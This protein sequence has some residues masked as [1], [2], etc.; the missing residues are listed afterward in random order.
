MTNSSFQRRH[1]FDLGVPRPTRSRLEHVTFETGL[2]C[3]AIGDVCGLDDA[4]L[5]TTG[6][7]ATENLFIHDGRSFFDAISISS[8]LSFAF[9]SFSS[10]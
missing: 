1:E 3:R 5:L 2:F 4:F 9:V 10:L 8:S 6:A 7:R